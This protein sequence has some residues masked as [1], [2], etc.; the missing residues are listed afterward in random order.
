MNYLCA[1]KSRSEAFSLNRALKAEGIISTV[2]N[3]PRKLGVSC[4]LSVVFNGGFE[5][6]V[7]TLISELGLKTFQGI[8]AK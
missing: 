7:R 2:I 1:F 6:R 3:T 8:F 5:S 4:G